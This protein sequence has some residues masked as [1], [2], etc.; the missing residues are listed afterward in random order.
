MKRRALITGIGAVTAL[1]NNADA[2]HER[3][4][5]GESGIVDGN[6]PCMGF[7]AT[8]IMS[9]KEARRTD[10]F[11][12]LA[13]AAA[14]EA[15]D[16]ACWGPEPPYEPARVA[17]IIGS[18]IGG[19]GTLERQVDVQRSNGSSAVSGLTVPMLM[20]NAASATVSMRFKLRGESHCVTSAC[21][22]GAQAILSGLRTIQTYEADAAVV[23]GTE[24]AATAFIH[25]A[26]LNAG[27]LSPTGRSLPFDV[28]RD[29]FVHGEGAGI[30]LL[31][32]A[33]A[34]EDRGAEAI[35]ELIG[36]GSSSDAFHITAPE[37]DG[38][39]A[40]AATKRA[41]ES[42]GVLP[43]EIHYINAHGTGTPLNDRSET[44]ALRA[45]LGE[46]AAGI[47]ISSAKSVI[48]HLM[49]AAG[50]VEAVATVQALRRRK[51][52]PTVGLEQLDPACEG[53]DHVMGSARPLDGDGRPLIAIS[54]SFGFGGHNAV[55]VLRSV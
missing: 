13:V 5:A 35:A 52:A 25:A 51:A 49:G 22:S 26:F 18:G 11:S 42:A 15:L 17:C 44:L 14:Q 43:E 9:R 29:G 54:P 45:S 16:Q 23:G 4:A 12:Q 41:L 19:L 7:D 6:G 20:A 37:P 39:M 48:G 10:R 3:W 1:G 33:D 2:L 40:A 34:A 30:L 24:G 47:P 55:L 21:A 8:T 53:L 32:A 36:Y 46:A 31:E 27:A 38:R 28:R 50:A